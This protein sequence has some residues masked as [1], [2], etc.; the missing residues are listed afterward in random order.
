MADDAVVEWFDSHCH[1]Q[2]E[3]DEPEPGAGP[4]E[5]HADRLAATLARAAEAGVTRMVCVGTGRRSSAEAVALARS[6][7]R[8]GGPATAEGVALWATVGLH[9]H[10]AVDG[11]DGLDEVLAAELSDD[12]G[13]P[14]TV[15]RLLNRRLAELR[16]PMSSRVSGNKVPSS[17]RRRP[18]AAASVIAKRASAT[19]A[20]DGEMVTS[21][22]L[23][24]KK[25]DCR[26]DRKS[27]DSTPNGAR[28][29]SAAIPKQVNVSA[30]ESSAAS[31]RNDWR[32]TP[33]VLDATSPNRPVG[34][35]T[36]SMTARN[37]VRTIR[38]TPATTR[39]Q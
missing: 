34:A 27:P 13:R 39:V 11:V 15:V 7:R 6:L 16:S 12:R 23:T 38:S 2:D 1:L 17:Q 20:V 19:K 8:P 25:D 29:S 28:M 9:P 26:S 37:S 3:F 4:I 18:C 32:S 24:A 33:S 36:L 5:P 21:A 30:P 22:I 31:G 35:K 10:D 14:G